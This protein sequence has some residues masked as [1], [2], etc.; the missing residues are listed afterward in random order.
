MPRFGRTS[1]TRLAECHP[2]LQRLFNEVIKTFDCTIL[3]GTRNEEDQNKAFDEGRSKVRFPDGKHNSSPSLAVDVAPWPIDWEDIR[4]F[5]LFAGYVRRT[6][7]EL[8][9]KVRGGH[10]WDG[11]F[12]IDDQSFNDSP[13]WELKE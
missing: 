1:K 3:C 9:I 6:A 7:E 13:H 8:G 2:D 5:Y 10:D 11:D 12:N 4:R